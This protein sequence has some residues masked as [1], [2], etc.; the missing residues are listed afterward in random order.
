MPDKQHGQEEE[1]QDEPSREEQGGKSV[2]RSAAIG[3]AAGA[4]VGA[5]TGAATSA[6]G[7]HG[8][9]ETAMK[10]PTRA[11]TTRSR[12]R[13]GKTCARAFLFAPRLHYGLLCRRGTLR[14]RPK[15]FRRRAAQW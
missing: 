10:K 13:R 6:L 11:R 15:G 1:T 5:A 4:A 12:T 7:L 2:A 14:R 9:S 8:D 3:A